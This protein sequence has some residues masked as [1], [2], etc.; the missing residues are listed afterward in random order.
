M[1]KIKTF[2][3][4]PLA[5][6]IACALAVASVAGAV[7]AAPLAGEK[8]KN[9][10][11]VSYEDENGNKYTAQSNEA[12]IIVAPQYKATIENDR[13]QNAAP[14]QTV[15]F[16]HTIVNTGNVA[17]TYNLTTHK[18]DGRP[19][20]D[21]KIYLDTNGNGQP[22]SGEDVITSLNLSPDETAN[23][24]VA[25][26]VPVTAV[27]GALPRID[28]IAISVN[29]GVVDDLAAGNGADAT[30]GT[31]SDTINVTTGP[32]LVLTKSSVVNTTDKTIMYTLTVKNTGRSNAI[33]VDILD[34]IPF[35]DTDGDGT[36]ET[37]MSLVA[38]SIV[39]NGL[40]DGIAI[41]TQGVDTTENAL[42][43]DV[44]LD[45]SI[46]ATTM[47]IKA[48][49]GVLSPDTTISVSYKVSYLDSW[50]AGADIDNT[51]MAFE[52]AGG[53]D[54]PV[55]PTN[56][57]VSNTT[58]DDVPQN[59]AIQ[60]EDDGAGV[61][62]S[63]VNDGKDDDGAAH[64][65]TQLVDT[66]A[67]GDTVIFTHTL[68]NQGNG[69]DIFNL[70]VANTD[71]PIGTVFT[72]WNAN[73]TVQLTDSDA[74]GIPDSGVLGQNE[75]A[76]IVIK[77]DLPAGASGDPAGGYNAVLT[78][79][80]SADD[81]V[82]DTTH[83]KLDEITA[84]AVDVAASV[85]S[86]AVQ[87]N[88]GFNDAGTE[89]AHNEGPVMLSSANVGAT[90]E[91]PLSVANES[92]SADSFLLSTVDVPAGWD[93]V[94][95]DTS[96]NTVTSTPFLPAGVTFD[97]V[98]VVTVSSDATQ[99][100]GNS[101]RGADVDGHDTVNDGITPA[102]LTDFDG[103]KDY[104]ITFKVTSSVDSARS[105]EISH[106]IDVNNI[107]AVTITPD[108][109]N[110]VQPGGTVEYP[111]TLKNDGNIDEA[112]E[113]SPTNTDPDWGSTTLIDT[114]G[115]GVGDT[116]LANLK[117]N[118]VIKVYNPDGGVSDVTLTDSD[119]DGIV[120]FPLKPGQYVKLIN[121][122]FAPAN[123]PQGEVN[124]TT[125]S[126]TDPN[127]T[128][129]RNIAEDNSNVILGQV[130]LTKTVAVDANCDKTPEGLFA[131]IQATKI[132][133]GQCAV[134]EIFAKNE[135]DAKVNNVIVTDI[136][137]TYTSLIDDSLTI[138]GVGKTK[139]IGDDE[140]EV[141]NGGVITY[142]LGTGTNAANQVGGIL[143]SGASSTVR[144]TV[145][146]DE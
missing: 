14:G 10:A 25:Y 134:W 74:D 35:V 116:E 131:E 30:E 64:S 58:H 46:D 92:G 89:N 95:K 31:S 48:T 144:F 27:N 132:E 57:P 67:S 103:D 146:I 8:I 32:V 145:K 81:A 133:P 9:L 129:V 37:Q 106:A 120:E 135:G 77:A 71:F 72:L 108:G 87:A 104:V 56:P 13:T 47:V 93:V 49:D 142:Y 12:V 86:G 122:V 28:L 24:I 51:F 16:S 22:D 88:T 7:H 63:G 102:V 94:F 98:A 3:R 76:T 128:R 115:D 42:G 54:Q 70:T 121:K 2:Q 141:S 75:L 85:T 79:T 36:K 100:L 114:T 39:T 123:A 23:I 143:L 138:D 19:N 29:S 18:P 125:L 17:D 80:S 15:Y 62:S 139:S 20:T 66:I 61:T 52:D 112:V 124:T 43:W 105:D 101:D 90:V 91:F 84:P 5:H 50:A 140:A 99:A 45:G 83:L 41:D 53:N 40:Q 82:K 55:D 119:N 111:H 136:V 4:S 110:Q 11:T 126:V 44:N 68:T 107:K 6:W 96:G 26:S 78:A 137:P 117:A 21:A 118:D 69:D 33:G 65:D 73:G 38:G 59:Y 127:S 109:Q 130:R 97:Y 60:A 1:K 34:V 113:L